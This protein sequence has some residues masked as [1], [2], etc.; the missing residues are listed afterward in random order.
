MRCSDD[1]AEAKYFFF[2]FILII[3]NFKTE[4]NCITMITAFKFEI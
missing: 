2:W 4:R 1:F 3:Y